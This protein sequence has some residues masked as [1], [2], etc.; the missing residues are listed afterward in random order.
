MARWW[1]YLA[2]LAGSMAVAAPVQVHVD[3]GSPA[4]LQLAPSSASAKAGGGGNGNAGGNGNSGNGGGNGNGDGGASG[5]GGG[6]GGGNGNGNGGSGNGGGNGNGNGGSGNGGGNSNGNGGSG[7][8][9]AGGSSG[10]GNSGGGSSGAS[11]GAG[12]AS[13]GSGPSSGGGSAGQG[14]GGGQNAGGRSAGSAS[15]NGAN[16]APGR[17]GQAPGLSGRAAS[18][19]GVVHVRE[20]TPRSKSKVTTA[21]PGAAKGAKPAVRGRSA[22]PGQKGKAPAEARRKSSSKASAPRGGGA[23]VSG[24][25]ASAARGR[26]APDR[27]PRAARAVQSPSEA[28]ALPKGPETSLEPIGSPSKP[29]Q[30]AGSIVASGLSDPD[31]ARLAALG[32]QVTSRTGG[33]IAPRVVR[34]RLPKGMSVVEARRTVQR[35]N[36]RASA[37]MDS[38]YYTDGETSECGDPGCKASVIVGWTPPVIDSC[39]EPPLIGLIDTGIDLDHEALKGQSI[40]LLSVSGE[41]GSTSSPDHGTAIAALLVGKPGSVAPGLVPQA[42]LVAVDAF[43]RKD[44]MADRAD[45]VS[46][47]GALETLADRGVRIVNLSLSGPPN[48]VLRMAIEAARAQ[49]IVLVAAVGNNGAGAEP[50]YPA[51]YPG[52]VAVTAVDRQLNIYRRAN[53]GSHIAFAAPGVEIRTA[54][55]KGGTA[56]RSGTSYAV[57]FVTAAMAM[58]RATD[59]ET[60]GEA[61]QK[62]LR[63]SAQ[64]LGAPGRDTT[65]GHGLVKMADLCPAPETMPIPIAGDVSSVAPLSRKGT[66]AP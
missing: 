61:L 12:G 6:N 52:V 26:S 62:R 30:A 38:Y 13:G 16:A 45:V 17:A 63:D 47:V 41:A 23:T 53:R 64:D 19:A 49:G 4:D 31:L 28:A 46:L 34:L 33:R 66:E 24:A 32:L 36:R 22:A 44:G 50:S 11:N 51:A 20:R 55:A 57:P 9:N 29:R 21:Q 54:R 35:L 40:E 2:I 58:M 15:S 48:E 14:G 27:G 37:D 65:F 3:F 56:A 5:N 60:N 8:G 59:P 1:R 18:K 43:S 39:G 10:N 42:K 7:T 25:A